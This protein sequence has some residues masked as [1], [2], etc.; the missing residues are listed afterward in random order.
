MVCLHATL[1]RLDLY[2]QTLDDADYTSTRFESFFFLFF[3]LLIF[4]FFFSFEKLQENFSD[5]VAAD[6]AGIP[7]GEV[8]PKV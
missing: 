3:F 5:V 6:R 7:D 8:A 1:L 2:K 4:I